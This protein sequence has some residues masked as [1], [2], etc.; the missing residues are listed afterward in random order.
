MHLTVTRLIHLSCN[1]ILTF[2][3]SLAG[4]GAAVTRSNFVLEFEMIVNVS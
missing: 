1:A 2:D 3:A 4:Y